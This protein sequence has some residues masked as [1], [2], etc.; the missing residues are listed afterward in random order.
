MGYSRN[1]SNYLEKIT[2][3]DPTQMSMANFVAIG[4][5][6]PMINS[7]YSLEKKFIELIL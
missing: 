1:I 2:L 3:L 4:V 6:I 5:K 7:G